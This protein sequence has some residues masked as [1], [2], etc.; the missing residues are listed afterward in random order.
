[1]PADEVKGRGNE[2]LESVEMAEYADKPPH[3]LSMGQK[4]RVAIAGVLAMRPDII[5]M[6]EPTSEL[7]GGMADQILVY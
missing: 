4:K 3:F 6:D 5:V 7:D 1:L 2:A